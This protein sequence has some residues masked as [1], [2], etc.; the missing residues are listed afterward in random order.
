M[1]NITVTEEQPVV[2][3]IE[4]LAPGVTCQ[5]FSNRRIFAMTASDSSRSSV[6]AWINRAMKILQ[7]WPANQLW[8][9][10]IDASSPKVMRTPYMRERIRVLLA[11]RPEIR[12]YIAFIPPKTYLAQVMKLGAKLIRGPMITEV[13]FSHDKAIKW[14]ES[15]I[16]K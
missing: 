10:V 1:L 12:G 15:K 7:D 2:S 13:F 8:L 9:I 6:D 14:L 11:A 4:V 3:D 5:W 16:E